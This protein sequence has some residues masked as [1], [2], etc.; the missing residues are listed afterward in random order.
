MIGTRRA[1]RRD[2]RAPRGRRRRPPLLSGQGP[3]PWPEGVPVF[4]LRLTKAIQL[5]SYRRRRPKS[6]RF[7]LSRTV[8]TST[9]RCRSPVSNSY[10]YITKTSSPS[11]G[12]GMEKLLVSDPSC[13]GKTVRE[14][15]CPI[16]MVVLRTREEEIVGY[17]RLGGIAV[18]GEVA[19]EALPYNV[20][21][22]HSQ[23]FHSLGI[24][25]YVLTAPAR[26]THRVHA[27]L[28][29]RATTRG[30][31]RAEHPFSHTSDRGHHHRD[32]H[33]SALASGCSVHIFAV[34][35]VSDVFSG[36]CEV[37]SRLFTHY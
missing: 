25:L 10:S 6:R 19:L 15:F 20:W 18:V 14:K 11:L 22:G 32:T 26:R 35:N 28:V 21:V 1:T 31:P 13:G 17:Q 2:L 24:C 9:L 37:V 33:S 34:V 5:S 7:L 36:N 16:D 12:I 30:P 8:R 3:L 23:L 27:S 29:P 4:P